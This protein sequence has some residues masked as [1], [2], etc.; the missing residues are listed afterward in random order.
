MT[1]AMLRVE[2]VTVRFRGVTAVNNVSLDLGREDSVVI[3][4]PNGAGKS[5]LFNVICGA[6]RPTSGRIVFEGIDLTNKSMHA[7]ARSGIVRKFQNPT[8]FDDLTVIE[9]LAIALESPKSPRAPSHHTADSL[10][11]LFALGTDLD[12]KASDLA[13]GTKQRL[14]IAM[15]LAARPKL[16]LL[17]EPT[18]GMTVTE[19]AEV[20]Q[21]LRRISGVYPV[22]VIEHDMQFVEAIGLRT[23]VMHRGEIIADGSFS[24]IRDN[25]YV[26]NVYLGS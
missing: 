25:E 7:F 26:Q 20:A 6:A 3:L 13:H 18:A 19:T 21:L 24:Q 1:E 9:N 15:T 2:S 12:T 8:V 5:T 4:G 17:D 10:V 23:L 11:E 22:V 16:L 14:D